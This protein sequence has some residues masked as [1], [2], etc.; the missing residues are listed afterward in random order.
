MIVVMIEYHSAGVQEAGCFART[1]RG[2]SD[3]A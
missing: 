3:A 2:Y 1:A